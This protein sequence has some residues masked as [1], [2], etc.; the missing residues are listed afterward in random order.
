[1]SFYVLLIIVFMHGS[2]PQPLLAGFGDAT[3]CQIS[4]GDVLTAASKNTD[5]DGVVVV[6]ECKLID[7][8][9]AASL[10]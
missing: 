10:K 5:V 7:S 3:T 4:E 8:A 1:M 2:G 6:D 9:K